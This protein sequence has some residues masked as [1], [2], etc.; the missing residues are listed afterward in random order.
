[1]LCPT[2]PLPPPQSVWACST[3]GKSQ[4][5]EA[6]SQSSPPP[7]PGALSVLM[8][9]SGG[10]SVFT[11]NRGLLPS[12]NPINHAK[13][14]SFLFLLPPNRC[15]P[16]LHTHRAEQRQAERVLVSSGIFAPCPVYP[17]CLVGLDQAKRI[18][19]LEERKESCLFCPGGMVTPRSQ[20]SC[21]L[22]HLHV[23]T[24]DPLSSRN[25]F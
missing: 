4:L 2:S 19:S 9:S 3:L 14:C 5:L 21:L 11:G 17:P 18:P 10:H 12:Q 23:S 16:C 24:E 7:S 22:P 25:L 13:F 8:K 20:G 15:L 6:N 1:M